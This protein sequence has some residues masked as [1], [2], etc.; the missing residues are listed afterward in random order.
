MILARSREQALRAVPLVEVK[1]KDH[2]KPV[3]T[4]KEAL[5]DPERVMLQANFGPPSAFDSGNLHG[6]TL[7]HALTTTN[8]KIFFFFWQ[9]KCLYQIRLSK[10]NSRLAINTIFT[11]KQLLLRVFLLRTE[12]MFSV[13][14]KTRI[15]FKVQSPIA[16]ESK[17]LSK[18]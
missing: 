12:S 14:P 8:N 1:Y 16:W 13:L 15:L 17:E 18:F 2:K 6:K 10:A 3:L 4:I 7:N 5:K 9:K 11:W